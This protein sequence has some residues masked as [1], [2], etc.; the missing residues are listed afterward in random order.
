M[1]RNQGGTTE[2][3]FVPMGMELFYRLGFVDKIKIDEVNSAIK[4]EDIK[5]KTFDDNFLIN[6]KI[7]NKI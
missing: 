3:C 6:G 4:L 2:S 1:G 5:I 7:K